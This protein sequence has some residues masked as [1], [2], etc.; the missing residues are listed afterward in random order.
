M[1]HAGGVV[2]VSFCY[3]VHDGIRKGDATAVAQVIADD[4]LM[5]EAGGLETRAEYVNNHLPA[6]IEFEKTVSIKRSPI[7]VVVLRQPGLHPRAT[8]PAH[9]KASRSTR[10]ARN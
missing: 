3:V 2:L 9:F 7:R 6:D 10:S 1:G 4:A 8:S 5:L